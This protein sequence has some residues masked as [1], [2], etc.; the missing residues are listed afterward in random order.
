VPITATNAKD[1]NLQRE[2]AHT[3]KQLSRCKSC[4]FFVRKNWFDLV[5][6]KAA[7][8]KGDDMYANQLW[9]D[10]D[11]EDQSALILAPTYGGIFTTEQ[12]DKLKGH[13]DVTIED[14]ESLPQGHT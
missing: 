7:W 2:L 8:D 12:R 10:L 5:E 4:M 6:M 11:Y 13:W 1:G 14:I 3:K 9:N